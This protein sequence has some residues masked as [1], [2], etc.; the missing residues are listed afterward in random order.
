MLTTS[1][2][3]AEGNKYYDQNME[4]VLSK[5]HNQALILETFEFEHSKLYYSKSIFCDIKIIRKIISFFLKKH[6]YTYLISII[7]NRYGNIPKLTSNKINGLIKNFKS[8][9]HF[10]RF[11]IR[12]KNISAVFL[13]QNGIQKGL[14]AAAKNC[15]VPVVEFQHGLIEKSHMAYSYNKAITYSAAAINLPDYFFSFSKYWAESVFFPVKAVIPIGNTAFHRNLSSAEGDNE[16]GNGLVV[17]SAN[18]YG[19]ELKRLILDFVNIDPCTRIFFKLHPNQWAEAPY[20]RTC[21]AAFKNVVVITDEK[22][23][24][25]LIRETKATLIIKSTAIY[26]ALQAQRIGIV[27]QKKGTGLSNDL[28]S[29]N[30]IFFIENAFELKE[31]MDEGKLEMVYEEGFF[32]KEFDDK[33]FAGFLAGIKE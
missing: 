14:F 13:T 6:D 24:G 21:F 27:Y 8:D 28:S 31:I 18:I 30:N 2:N 23:M 5:L 15:N 1:R 12:I 29:L 7:S 17:A 22:S 20:Y 16:T 11:L 26:E 19:E 25:E 9:R 4:D 10:Y 33:L 32:F 3:K